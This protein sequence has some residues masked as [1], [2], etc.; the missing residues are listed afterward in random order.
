MPQP[1]DRKEDLPL[2][3]RHCVSLFARQF[4]KE[5][6]G[7][8]HRAQILTQHSW[9]GNV[10]ELENVIRHGAMMT[11]GDLIDVQEPAALFTRC[12]GS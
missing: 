3:Q 7:L 4:G 2:L 9:P 12:S 8:T 5:I 1:V 11:M 6:R 10:R